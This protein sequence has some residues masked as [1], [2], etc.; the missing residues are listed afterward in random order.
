MSYVIC[1]TVCLCSLCGESR[2]KE[3]IPRSLYETHLQTAKTGVKDMLGKLYVRLAR[4][5]RDMESGSRKKDKGRSKS[6]I[7]VHDK[8]EVWGALIRV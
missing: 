8:M 5:W 1:P 3:L 6:I 7:L 4:A 2:P